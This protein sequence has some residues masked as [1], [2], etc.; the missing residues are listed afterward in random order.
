[1]LSSLMKQKLL[2]AVKEDIAG[3]DITTSLIPEKK[4][5][6]LIT[7]KSSGIIAGI[8]ELTFLFNSRKVKV[9]SFVKDGQKI[10][11]GK[12]I[13]ELI[14]LNK[15]ILE[16]ER[17]ALNVL[18]RMSGVATLAGKAKQKSLVPVSATRKTI[19]GFNEFDKKACV[20]AGIL[21]HR[22]NLNELILLKENHLFFFKSV[23]EALIKAK[24]YF[25]GKKK[26]E[27]EV[28]SLKQAVEAVKENPD[29]LMLDNFS[30]KNAEKAIKLI[31]QLNKKTVIELSGGI[32]LKNLHE[33][34]LL[35]PDFI[36]LG[37]ITKNAVQV[38]FSLKVKK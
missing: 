30:V 8:E 1:M 24:K 14:G 20:L 35:K 18:G 3:K 28:T 7:A 11:K 17:T 9:K 25:K 22:K 4:C 32:N 19:P 10:I 15:D 23:S 26:I 2:S 12:K 38:D 13:M 21:P 6:A 16:I 29:I 5:I 36:S 27:V 33:Y 37:E 31:R 34:S